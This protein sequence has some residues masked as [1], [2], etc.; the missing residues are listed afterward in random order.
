M[1]ILAIRGKNLASLS[2]EFEID[3]QAEPLASAGLYAITGATG[4]GKSTLLDALCLALYERTPRLAKATSKGE[5]VPDVGDNSITPSDPR[6]ILRRGAAEGFAEVDFVGSDGVAYRSRWNVRRSRNK[7]EGKLQNSDISLT[8][9]HDGQILGDHR[10]TETLRLIESFIGLNFDQFTR[11]VLLAQ[12]DFAAF[13]KATDDERA[14][15]LQTLT[16]TETFSQISKQAFAR[17]KSEN[18][19]LEL[20]Q[21]RLEDQAPL[22]PEIRAEKEIQRQAQTDSI[23]VLDDRKALTE[24]HLR[25]H[26]Q[27]DQLRLVQADA[28]QK[29]EAAINE[30]DLAAPRFAH[31]TRVEQVQPARPM[32]MELERLTQQISDTEKAQLDSQTALDVAN[33][34]VV[35]HEAAHKTAVNQLAASETRTVLAQADIN[36]AKALDATINAVVPQFEAARKAQ[37]DAQRH[38][39][40]EQSQKD[41]AD[42]R[43]AQSHSELALIDSWIAGHVQLKPLAEG[44]Q[45]WETLFA[46]AQG[47]QTQLDKTNQE[48]KELTTTATGITKAQEKALADL[49]TANGH[50]SAAGQKLDEL[51]QACAAVDIDKLTHVRQL[52]EDRRDHLQAASQLWQKR[53]D[54]QNQQVKQREQQQA[55]ESLLSSCNQVLLDDAKAQPLLEQDLSTAEQ[56]LSLAKL[57]ASKGAETLRTALQADQPCPVCGSVEHPYATH[58]PVADAMLKSLQDQVKDKRKSL[59]ALLQRA[60]SATT[61]KA[62]AEQQLQQLVMD[63]AQLDVGLAGVLADWNT[64]VL[65]SEVDAVPE[66]DRIVWFGSQQVSN[67][68]GLDQ[69]SQQEKAHRSQLKLKEAAQ[70]KL[71]LAKKAVDVAR[72][73]LTQLEIRSSA[74]SQ[75]NAAAQQQLEQGQA[76]LNQVQAQLDGA[77]ATPDWRQ[78]W[79]QNPAGFVTACRDQAKDWSERQQEKAVLGASIAALQV[80]ISGYVNACLLAAQQLGVQ[81]ELRATVEAEL[82]NRRNERA[83]LFGGRPIVDVENELFSSVD[84]AKKAVAQAQ[85]TLIQAQGDVTRLLE[86]VRLNGVQ[87]VQQRTARD[88]AGA[89]LSAWLAEF[90]ALAQAQRDAMGQDAAAAWS[91]LTLDEL[92]ALLKVPPQWLTQERETLQQLVQSVGAAQAVLGTRKES[93]AEHEATRAENEDPGVLRQTLTQVTQELELANEALSNLRLEL[94]R[95]DD[96]LSTSESLRIAIDKQS[97]IS[98]VWSQLSDLIGS[99]DGKK[100][101]NFAQQYTLDILLGYGNSHLQSL[102]RRY[103]LQR[104]KDTLGLLVVDQ[105]MGDE[106]RSVHSLSGGESFLVSLALAL[107]LASLSSHRVKVESLFIDEGFG[108]LDAESL[109]VAMDALDNLQALGRKVGVISHV[110]EMT[111]RIGTRVQVQRQSG[112]LSRIVVC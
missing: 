56:S 100:F 70:T 58:S 40:A 104:I 95:D 53:C 48:I 88:I 35:I 50:F 99:A 28:T 32:W 17:M 8:R 105:D 39:Q 71:D 44:W 60:A 27:W 4:A 108:S 93:L 47:H 91:V 55:Q 51:T 22:L 41:E 43:L 89:Q 106:V 14:E 62:S 59:D 1:K 69:L 77:F 25:W 66:P 79:A 87:L 112:G 63:S 101:R 76:Q 83:A 18:E 34:G 111:E 46:Q 11:A 74:T 109:R 65:W 45:L 96:R 90:N 3:F 49:G 103:R 13:L 97:A 21:S 20:L 82:I 31:L 19:K 26:Q 85:A 81:S 7:A 68:A 36:A 75:S 78:N 64:L 61:S 80:Q 15:L 67:K 5:S 54:V 9:I 102:S 24:G 57:A 30:R 12:N 29:L 72:D 6:T 10:K 94:A 98:K 33:A 42:I 84:L 2:S 92:E 23:K 37:D 16:G 52:L 110:Q 86:A 38:L 73:V 107:G